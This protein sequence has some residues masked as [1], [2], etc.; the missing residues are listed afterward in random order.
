MSDE[1]N[2]SRAFTLVPLSWAIG[3]AAGYVYF[4]AYVAFRPVTLS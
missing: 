1:T 2:I 3:A 4:V